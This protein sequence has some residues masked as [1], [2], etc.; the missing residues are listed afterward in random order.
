MIIIIVINNNNEPFESRQKTWVT[1]G[2]RRWAC[3]AGPTEFSRDKAKRTER[4]ERTKRS[5]VDTRALLG[6]WL[7]VAT[8]PRVS[9]DSRSDASR[10]LSL[11]THFP[12]LPTSLSL[13]LFSFYSFLSFHFILFR[14]KKAIGKNYFIFLI[15]FEI[16]N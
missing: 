1:E 7:P 13:I 10:S 2:S 9:K 8:D 3:V 6:H 12:V 16:Y 11:S 5:D 15:D 4:I 14:L